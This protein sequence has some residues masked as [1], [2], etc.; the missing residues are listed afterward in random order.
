[1]FLL[2]KAKSNALSTQPTNVTLLAHYN[3][4]KPCYCLFLFS[5]VVLKGLKQFTF[6]GYKAWEV[7]EGN[8]IIS[9][10]NYCAYFI[11]SRLTCEPCPS[12]TNR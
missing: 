7:C 8:V 6:K 5:K 2:D 12:I 3:Y 1:M 11:A 4:L 10:L 9:R